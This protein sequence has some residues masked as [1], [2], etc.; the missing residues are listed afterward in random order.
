MDEC[1]CMLWPQLVSKHLQIP[2]SFESTWK[3]LT[4]ALPLEDDRNDRNSQSIE[5]SFHKHGGDHAVPEAE[6]K[7]TRIL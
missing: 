3:D 7:Q 5:G 1:H 6:K 2:Q 4:F